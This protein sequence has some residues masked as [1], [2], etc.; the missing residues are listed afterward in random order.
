MTS[1][2]VERPAQILILILMM[3]STVFF[4][5]KK[6]KEKIQRFHF[7]H[8]THTPLVCGHGHADLIKDDALYASTLTNQSGKMTVL[9]Q[10]NLIF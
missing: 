9:F 5:E 2:S 7:R 3:L 10:P 8:I 4:M 1:S 6:N